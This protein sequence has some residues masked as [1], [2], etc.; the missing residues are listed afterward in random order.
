MP[1]GMVPQALN[2]WEQLRNTGASHL[3]IHVETAFQ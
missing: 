3:V 1:A 2:I